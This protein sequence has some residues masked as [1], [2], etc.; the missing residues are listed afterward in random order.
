MGWIARQQLEPKLGRPLDL[1]QAI[2]MQPAIQQ[3]L[4]L[5]HALGP[6]S[7]ATMPLK[8]DRDRLDC[9]G[10]GDDSSQVIAFGGRLA[11]LQRAL[12]L[13]QGIWPELTLVDQATHLGED[14]LQVGHPGSESS[15][16]LLRVSAA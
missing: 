15:S 7:L 12:G 10:G 1:A 9:L 8:S 13:G 2:V 6:A 5:A 11:A 14:L 16:A 3:L 4:K